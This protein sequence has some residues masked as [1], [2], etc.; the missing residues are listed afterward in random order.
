MN[1]EYQPTLDLKQFRR[2]Q[3]IRSLITQHV[4]SMCFSNIPSADQPV[5]LPDS[6]R[7]SLG[8]LDQFNIPVLAI[9]ASDAKR[10]AVGIVAVYRGGVVQ[11]SALRLV[12]VT[13]GREWSSD[14]TLRLQVSE[15]EWIVPLALTL[16]A[17]YGMNPR[18]IGSARFAE[19]V[20]AFREAS[21]NWCT[22]LAV[23]L[24]SGGAKV[25]QPATAAIWMTCTPSGARRNTR[26]VLPV[27]GWTAPK[28]V[29]RFPGTH[30]R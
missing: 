10:L 16:S 6:S 26:S 14:S 19:Q 8:A 22:T 4:D 9:E 28:S 1:I 17:H 21:V 3:K 7:S 20:Q 27:L 30:P 11:T 2:I 13:D 5:Y 29:V 24:F 15:L 25:A 18:G 23:A 12:P